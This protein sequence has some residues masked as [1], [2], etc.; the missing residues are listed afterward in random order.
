MEAS[1]EWT[2]GL[3]EQSERQVLAW[4]T[5]SRLTAL[6]QHQVVLVTE[7]LRSARH[8]NVLIAKEV[9]QTRD[10]EARMMR[11]VV[12]FPYPSLSRSTGYLQECN[13]RFLM[14]GA[15]CIFQGCLDF[16]DGKDSFPE[17]FPKWCAVYFLANCSPVSECQCACLTRP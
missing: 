9:L 12:I 14:L 8:E 6:I 15:E 10:L 1:E 13:D 4:K 5:A 2:R 3:A 11:S 17:Q 7:L 16:H